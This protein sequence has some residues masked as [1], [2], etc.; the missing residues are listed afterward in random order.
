M[1]ITQVLEIVDKL[2]GQ[3]PEAKEKQKEKHTKGPIRDGSATEPTE[4]EP[5]LG[6]GQRRS[7]KTNVHTAARL[8]TGVKI[9]R[10][11]RRKRKGSKTE[12]EYSNGAKKQ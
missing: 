3:R 10:K 8:A 1:P 6:T 4:R 9:V 12:T 7:A 5:K 2:Y 11:K